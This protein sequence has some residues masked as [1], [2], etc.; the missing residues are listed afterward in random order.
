MSDIPE[1][2]L[3]PHLVRLNPEQHRAVTTI[4]GPLLIL[5][6]AGGGQGLQGR[7]DVAL[8]PLRLGGPAPAGSRVDLAV[9]HPRQGL[10][11]GVEPLALAR[12]DGHDRH[13][14]GSLQPGPVEVAPLA[15][16]DVGHVDR[17]DRGQVELDHLQVGMKAPEIVGKDIDGNEIK[18][19]QYAGQV[20]VLDFWGF[21]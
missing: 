17:D 3:P 7:R 1:D 20:V 11:Q 5:A 21:W 16:Q 19:S 8:Q 14:E 18:L 4:E 6:G 12:G 15:A 9:E 13:A 10:A 2:E